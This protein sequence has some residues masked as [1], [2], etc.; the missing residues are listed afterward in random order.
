MQW[1]LQHRTFHKFAWDVCNHKILRYIFLFHLMALLGLKKKKSQTP[2]NAID[3]CTW[4]YEWKYQGFLRFGYVCE[5]Q[6]V[7]NAA[8]TISLINT[9]LSDFRVWLVIGFLR[10]TEI[11]IYF[12]LYFYERKIEWSGDSDT[13]YAP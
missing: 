12:L 13:F 6:N 3:V 11:F 7:S 4:N 8:S 10:L 9:N 5:C 1:S 2:D